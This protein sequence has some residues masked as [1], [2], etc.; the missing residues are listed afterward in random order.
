MFLGLIFIKF[1][2][3]IEA[4]HRLLGRAGERRR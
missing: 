2:E 4:L 1:W 3:W